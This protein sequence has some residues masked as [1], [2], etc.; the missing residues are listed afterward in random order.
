MR[1]NIIIITATLLLATVI[2]QQNLQIHG[3]EYWQ[4]ENGTIFLQLHDTQYKPINNATC[5][6]TAYKPNKTKWINEFHLTYL[7][8][9]NGLYYVDIYAP[10]EPGIY[11]LDVTCSYAGILYT[12]QPTNITYE[13]NLQSSSDIEN[14][15]N[16]DCIFFKTTVSMY[17]ETTYNITT[18]NVSEMSEITVTWVGINSKAADIEIYN[19]NTSAWDT[20]TT[21]PSMSGSSCEARVYYSTD[22]NDN[23]THY[24]NN[25]QAMTRIVTALSSTLWTD[26]FRLELHDNGS[27]VAGCGCA[28][29]H[30]HDAN[31]TTQPTD[32]TILANLTAAEIWNYTD[33]NLT[34]YPN[35][36][37]LTATQVWSYGTR[38]LTDYNQTG[39]LNQ[40]NIIENLINSLANITAY[41]IW[42]YTTRTLTGFGTLVADIWSYTPRTVN[43]TC[44]VNV[45]SNCSVYVEGKC[46]VI[47]KRITCP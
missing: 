19:Y 3:T 15:H 12:Y 17:H 10:N 41:D 38:T 24:F 16:I 14:V 29:V 31:I 34:F 30:V 42:T 28:E 9:S 40:L 4:G 23:L 6:L 21:I 35:F 13:G 44:D 26:L 43:A 33:R 27:V 8:N 20:L 32:L 39:M 25:S 2:A 18:L 11:M 46:P 7:N 37:T 36:S 22:I 5:E 1:V 47:I 45:T